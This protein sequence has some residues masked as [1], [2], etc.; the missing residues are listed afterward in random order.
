MSSK[1]FS[2][3]LQTKHSKAPRQKIMLILVVIVLAGIGAY[4][5]LKATDSGSQQS[6]AS[7]RQGSRATEEVVIPPLAEKK[8][9][10]QQAGALGMKRSEAASAGMMDEEQLVSE[11]VQRLQHQFAESIT[12][13]A[14]QVSLKAMRDDLLRTYPDKGLVLFEHII[15][16]AFPELAATILENIAKMDSYDSWLLDNMLALNEMNILEQQGVIWEK[17]R[18]LFGAA[19]EEI[20]RAEISAEEE[21]KASVRQTVAMLDSAYDT[22]MDERL[23]LLKSAFA[24]SFDAT[25][26]GEVFNAKGVMAQVF[27][28]FDSVQRDLKA[29]P[30]EARQQRINTLRRD[31]GFTENQIAQ[32]AE[33]DQQLEA[34]WQNGYEYMDARQNAEAELSGA[35]LETELDRLRQHYFKDEAHTIEREE[36]DLGF[37]RYTRPRV[38]GRN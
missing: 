24:E 10:E 1:S 31:M 5:V 8:R 33:R 7:S 13:V 30:G 9:A 14:F 20:W 34:R 36:E 12:S 3:P 15:R 22:T 25:V 23:F 18:E 32:L 38:Y 2:A 27:F 6:Q 19:A 11:L 4:A 35:A 37:F 21:R 28:G 26:E 17:R 16:G 29:L